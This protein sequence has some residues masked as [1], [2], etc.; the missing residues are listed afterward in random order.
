M[1]SSVRLNIHCP[2]CENPKQVG[3]FE[4]IVQCPCGG[5]LAIG[6]AEDREALKE[7]FASKLNLPPELAYSRMD[8]HE[9]SLGGG[10]GPFIIYAG[11]LRNLDNKPVLQQATA[12]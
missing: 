4:N 5:M 3:I 7:Q 10:Y 8:F 11:R 2:F 6:F 9:I 12:G 1:A